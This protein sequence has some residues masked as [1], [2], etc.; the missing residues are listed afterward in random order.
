M[1]EEQVPV[2][3]EVQLQNTNE[4]VASPV[5][6]SSQKNEEPQDP[7]ETIE[8]TNPLSQP[9]DSHPLSQNRRGPT[10]P[11]SEDPLRKFFEDLSPLEMLRLKQIVRDGVA[12]TSAP[13][14]STAPPPETESHEENQSSFITF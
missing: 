13:S 6:Q 14:K 7:V 2:I 5:P 3:P 10:D 4:K 8:E 1:G 11:V 9:I 12:S